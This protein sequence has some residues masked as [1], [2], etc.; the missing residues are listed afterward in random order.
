MH[1]TSTR[2]NRHVSVAGHGKTPIFTCFCVFPIRDLAKDCACYQCVF[3]FVRVCVF[4]SDT[5]IL[6]VVIYAGV[7]EMEMGRFLLSINI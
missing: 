6:N 1:P 3:S 7:K 5:G 4:H 2:C